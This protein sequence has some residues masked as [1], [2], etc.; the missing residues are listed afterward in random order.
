[1]IR[2]TG[3]WLFA[4]V[5]LLGLIQL[6]AA[7]AAA[8]SRSPVYYVTV[9]RGLTRPGVALVRQALREA[10]AANATVLVIELRGSGS[11][12]NTWPLARELAD[13]TVPVATYIAPRGAQSGP[14]GTLMVAAAHVAAMAPGATVGFA[15]P[16]VDVPASFSAST[17]QLLVNDAVTQLAGWA[18]ARGHN[19]DW[20]EQ[21]AR[22]GAIIDAERAQQLS[23]PLIDL[24]ADQDQ[25]LPSLQGR[26]VT[27]A[28]GAQRQ[29]ETLGAQV[30]MVQPS[31]WQTLGQLLAVPTIAFV[32]FVVGGIGLYL[33]LANPGVGIPGIAGALLVIAAIVGFIL[34]EVRPVAVLLL[35]IGLVLVGLEY[36]VLSH[37]G[38]TIAGIVLLVLGALFLVDPTRSPG[39]DVS[40]VAIGGVATALAGATAALVTIAVRVRS[41]APVTGQSAMLGQIAEVRQPLDPDGMVYVN[42]AL[43]AA[44]SDQGTIPAGAF[45]QIAGVDGLRLFVRAVDET[46]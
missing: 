8:Q 22:T 34:G 13:A 2:R 3:R 46:D 16:L 30:I 17:Q 25:L 42:G 40:Y 28:N 14:V 33:E 36:V 37:G 5:A 19:A 24:V 10:E 7:S 44:W 32:L 9:E 26:Q 43:W 27:L 29:L 20:L 45:V 1:M 11:I 35:A 12:V 38:L 41:Q 15:A 18:R 23:P 6:L 39:L 21:A 31:L 4:C